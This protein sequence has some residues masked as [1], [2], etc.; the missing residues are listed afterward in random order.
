MRAPTIVP[1]SVA[2]SVPMPSVKMANSGPPTTPKI[3]KEAYD[4]IYILLYIVFYL[5]VF[6]N[7]NE[8]YLK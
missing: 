1:P 5:S 4:K 3:V 2:D 7:N 6:R 8:H